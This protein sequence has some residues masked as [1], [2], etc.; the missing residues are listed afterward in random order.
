MLTIKN[1]SIYNRKDSR[2]LIKDF[3]FVL[4]KRDKVGI[5]GEEGNGKSTL[6]KSILGLLDGDFEVSGEIGKSG[7]SIGYL[8]QIM[9]KDLLDLRAKD[10]LEK[11]VLVD[12]FDYNRYYSLLSEFNINEE[13]FLKDTK[14]SS[15]SGGEKIKSQL[16]V[17]MM[18]NPTLLLLDEPTNDLD[19]EALKWI[20]DFIKKLTIPMIFVSHDEDL[21]DYTANRIIFIEQLRRKNEPKINIHNLSFNDF[22]EIRQNSIINQ[23]RQSKKDHE[24]FDKKMERYRRVY[25]SVENALGKVS[26][27]NPS[28]GKNLKDKMHTVKSLGK[29]FEKEKEKL[30][31]MPDYE[32]PVFFDFMYKTNIHSSKVVLDFFLDELK[33]G[34]RILSRDIRLQI[35]GPKKIGIIGKNGVGKTTLIKEIIKDLEKSKIKVGYMPQDYLDNFD[36]SLSPVEFLKRDF[37]KEEESR[38]RTYLGSMKFTFD[39]MNHKIS[40]LSGGQKA[41]LY[42]ISMIVDEVEVMVLDE[43]TRNLSPLTGPIIRKAL[44]DF[45]GVIIGISHDRTFIDQVLEEVYEL[46]EDGLEKIKF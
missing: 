45:G 24:E 44:G 23:E 40:D 25:D 4:N 29:R 31:E 18:K 32:E 30:T 37:T 22:R 11:E 2:F 46:K 7:E 5:I 38:L 20:K 6:L 1:L 35:I 43:P 13:I 39:E 16:L 19:L 3:N 9:G 28:E 8:P 34:D 42:F 14:F 27:G 10:Y 15:L 36:L 33:V 17:L 41:K 21:L 12:T 26:R